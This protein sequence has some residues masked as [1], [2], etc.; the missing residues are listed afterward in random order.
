MRSKLSAIRVS[1]CHLILVIC[2][3][4]EPIDTGSIRVISLFRD[5]A[6]AA[7]RFLEAARC[8][9]QLRAPLLRDP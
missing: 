2:V 7:V 6:L 1:G 8:K 4:A 5:A 3:L 9:H